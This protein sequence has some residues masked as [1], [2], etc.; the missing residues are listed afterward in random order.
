[1]ADLIKNI[2]KSLGMTSSSK[3]TKLLPNAPTTEEMRAE[4]PNYLGDLTNWLKEKWNQNQSSQVSSAIPNPNLGLGNLNLGNDSYTNKALGYLGLGGTD[5]TKSGIFAPPQG[6][7]KQPPAN[8]NQIPQVSYSP[9]QILKNLSTGGIPTGGTSTTGGVSTAQPTTEAPSTTTSVSPQPVLNQDELA[10]IDAELT[11][12]KQKALAIQEKLNQAQVNK[13]TAQK[14]PVA[15]SA[16]QPASPDLATAYDI[17]KKKL[18]ELEKKY[19]TENAQAIA[20]QLIDLHNK[21]IEAT[22][23]T[24]ETNYK[25]GR[26]KAEQ[27]LADTTRKIERGYQELGYKPGF[28]GSTLES[29]NRDLSYANAQFQNVNTLLERTKQEALAKAEA[30]QSADDWNRYNTIFNAQI[31]LIDE[32]LKNVANL[33]RQKTAIQNAQ[34]LENYRTALTDIAQQ[35]AAQ[36]KLE[37]TIS[38]YVGAGVDWE[39]LTPETRTAIEQSA[40]EAGIPIESIKDA[41]KN[42]AIKGTA[43]VGN[44]LVF[45]DKNG[46]IIKSVVG[47]TSE[48]ASSDLLNGIISGDVSLSDLS[49][50]GRTAVMDKLENIL[51]THPVLRVAYN[52]REL[53]A[54]QLKSGQVAPG[55]TIDLGEA[56]YAICQ[57]LMGRQGDNTFVPDDKTINYVENAFS[58]LDV[59]NYL[60]RTAASVKLSS[61]GGTGISIV[62]TPL[63]DYINTNV[64]PATQPESNTGKGW[65]QR[66][67]GE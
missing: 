8:N 43:K 60:K 65:I 13:E 35:K 66:L 48:S 12:A 53:L 62:N 64:K 46:N 20:Q 59:Y 14:P 1:M 47:S 37:N 34:S 10:K 3:G 28:P 50:K 26:Q 54:N 51:N 45:Y 5:I 19:G 25:V 41:M 61:G 7:N 22:K 21:N 40:Q 27:A 9:E 55:T 42:T 24:A 30:S 31:K 23:A 52:E 49:A 2:N 32:H 11:A 29:L 58:D 16:N 6:S 56:K 4:T 33:Q 63:T 18:N 57:E 15:S 44:T 17:I 67:F 39:T 38:P 36:T